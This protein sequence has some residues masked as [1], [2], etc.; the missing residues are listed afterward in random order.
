MSTSTSEI[1]FQRHG[2]VIK[3]L[4]NGLRELP[5]TEDNDRELQLYSDSA[6]VESRIQR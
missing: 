3:R 1:T 2:C 4:L 5:M 6:K